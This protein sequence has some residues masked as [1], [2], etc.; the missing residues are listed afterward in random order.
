MLRIILVL[1]FAAIVS[2][3]ELPIVSGVEHQP[4]AAQAVRLVEALQILG[5]PLLAG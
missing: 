3:Q 4:L 5:E 1:L 2:A